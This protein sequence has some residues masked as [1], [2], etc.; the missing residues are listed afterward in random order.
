MPQPNEYGALVDGV[1]VSK[2]PLYSTWRSMHERCSNPF[3]AAYANYGARGISVCQAWES[4]EQFTKD[5][6]LKPADHLTL[7][8]KDNFKGYNPEN[9]IW[10]TRSNQCVNR[11]KFKNNTS[12]L[13]GV[14]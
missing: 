3:D 12:S 11:R 1:L 13:T 10:D 7:E 4:F 14:V 8:R 6:G 5:M 2:H 9:C